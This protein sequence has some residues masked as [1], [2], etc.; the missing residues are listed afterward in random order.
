MEL[1]LLFF[2]LFVIAVIFS[3]I[4]FFVGMRFWRIKLTKEE[5]ALINKRRLK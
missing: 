5:Q 3:P 2:M 1:L 4:V